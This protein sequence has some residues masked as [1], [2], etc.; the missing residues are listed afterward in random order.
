MTYGNAQVD[1]LV[2]F[3]TPQEEYNLFHSNAGHLHIKY[4]IPYKQAK[5]IIKNCPVCRPLHLRIVPSGVNPRGIQPNE[6]WQMD[7][8]HVPLFGRYSCVHVTIDTYSKFLWAT[9]QI[10]KTTHHVIQHLVETFAIMG[11]P[12]MIKT[13]NGP[14]YTSKNFKDFCKLYD[15]VHLTG[16]EYNPQGQALVERVHAMLKTQIKKLKRR[17]MTD[18]NMHLFRH[19]Q[20]QPKAL[21]HQALFILNFLNL[22]QGEILTRAERHF[23]QKTLETI[24][25]P[26]WI[27]IAADAE[28]QP[29]ILLYRGKGYVYVSTENGHRQWLPGRWIQTCHNQNG[30]KGGTLS[31][32]PAKESRS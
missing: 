8:T 26:I 22:P 20:N 5:Q 1:K 10:G 7:V 19:L 4:K 21:L 9:A 27:K 2:M 24:H 25:E 14:A 16:I 12:A 11:I 13:D 6:L 30:T 18:L 31:I 3:K 23:E 32:T 15:I 28:W 17:K 29:G